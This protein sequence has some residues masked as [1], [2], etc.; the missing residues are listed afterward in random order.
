MNKHCSISKLQFSIF[1]FPFSIFHFPFSIL[2]DIPHPPADDRHKADEHHANTYGA[3]ADLTQ[4]IGIIRQRQHRIVYHFPGYT[5][6]RPDLAGQELADG[7]GKKPDAHHHGHDLGRGKLGDHRQAYGR[8]AELT[9]DDKEI[10]QQERQQRNAAG[11]AGNQTGQ[12]KHT[13][14]QTQEKKGDAEL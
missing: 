7:A 5:H 1:N 3:D 10:T 12:V 4:D 6:Q 14:A 8:E 9:A 2:M 13:E 11:I